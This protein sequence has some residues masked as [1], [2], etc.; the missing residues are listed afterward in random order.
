MRQ[1]SRPLAVRRAA[2]ATLTVLALGGL[3][4]CGG[5]SSP[6]DDSAADATS[7]VAGAPDGVEEGDEVDAAE[8]VRMVTDGL[9]A[10]TTAHIAMTMSLGSAGEMSAEGD[11]DYTTTP[12]QMAMTMSSPMGGGDIDIRLVDG[13]MYLSLGELTQGKFIEFDPA[14]AKGPLAGLGME[15][16]LDQLDPGKALANMEDGISKVVFVGEE[17]GL[18][19]YE[20]TVDM[21]K[22][23]DQLGGD[24]PPA[25]ESQV[26]DSV[27]YD[28]WLDDEGRFTRLSIDEL[29]VGGATGSMEMTVSGWGEDV[30][31]EA[32]AADE[33]TEMPGLGSM[34]QGMGGASA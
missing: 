7:Q 24:L 5:D 4:A 28:L 27:S 30:D 8:F 12:P 1:T 29:P 18:D 33:I 16:M 26:P 22:M 21:Q 20:L 13:I 23:I 19:H 31:I 11:I 32:P 17:D 15:G 6:S 10:S 9:E 14:D 34:L 2:T 25:A 3:A